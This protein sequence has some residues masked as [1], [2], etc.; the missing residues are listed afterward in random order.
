MLILATEIIRKW[1]CVGVAAHSGY[2][3]ETRTVRPPISIGDRLA[4]V[5]AVAEWATRNSHKARVN[6]FQMHAKVFLSV[7]AAGFVG[8]FLG[9]RVIGFLR[10]VITIGIV[11]QLFASFFE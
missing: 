1:A 10:F 9:Y 6:R 11:A 2:I 8:E 4:E 3:V 7:L 5:I